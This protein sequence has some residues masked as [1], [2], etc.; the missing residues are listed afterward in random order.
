MRGKLCCRQEL[1]QPSAKTVMRPDRDES[2][3]LDTFAHKS[4]VEKAY[5]DLG[6][7]DKTY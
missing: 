1:M 5:K 6:M 3:S 4:E 2:F 7:K